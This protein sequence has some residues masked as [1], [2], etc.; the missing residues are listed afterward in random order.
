MAYEFLDH[1][2]D[3]AVK[4]SSEGMEGLFDEGM[5]AFRDILLDS[6]VSEP[7]RDVEEVTI[8]LEAEDGESL[9][10]G[11]LNELLFLFETRRFVPGWSR[12]QILKTENP[13]R[14]LAIVRGETFDPERHVLKAE[15]KAATFHDLKILSTKDGLEA[16]VVFDL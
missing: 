15:I 14:L 2:A 8:D 4:L 7:I 9:L 1:T 6:E 11:Y 10:V 13:G 12:F 5:H 3:V 16:S